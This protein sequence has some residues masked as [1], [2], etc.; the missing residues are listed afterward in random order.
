MDGRDELDER[1]RQPVEDPK[2]LL[3]DDVTAGT[4]YLAAP[5]VGGTAAAMDLASGG[6]ISSSQSPTELKVTAGTVVGSATDSGQVVEA[7][8]NSFV[9]ANIP[10]V[11]QVQL[12]A[13]A[14]NGD[15]VTYSA[16]ATFRIVRGQSVIASKPLAATKATIIGPTGNAV[17]A[18][19]KVQVRDIVVSGDGS[20]WYVDSAGWLRQLSW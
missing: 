16:D 3:E 17:Q 4:V 9:T 15:L 14:P 5:Y 1:D 18:V 7:N 11:T 19:G 10:S 20:A 8:G 12:A 2:R 6:L 13:S